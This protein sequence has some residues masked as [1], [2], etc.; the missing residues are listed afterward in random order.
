[1]AGCVAARERRYAEALVWFVLAYL[2]PVNTTIIA[3]P[4]WRRAAAIVALAAAGAASF[5][6]ARGQRAAL[7]ATALA[8]F[9]VIPMFGRVVNYPKL[10][11]Q[12][13]TQ[14]A[15]WAR[16]STPADAVFM[17]PAFGKD[18]SP[19]IFRSEAL[20]A[21]YVDWKGGGQV[22]YLK[23]LGEQWWA[24][25]QQAGRLLTPDEYR[26]LGIDYVVVRPGHGP[27][28]MTPVFE[29]ARFAVYRL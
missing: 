8:A 1:V 7:A 9:F 2:V 6:P 26:G 15:R 20:R 25:W 28:G 22:N 13:V 11:T 18:L 10:H 19:G 27:P 4:D 24:R 3:L 16:A 23:E 5:R 12:E 29:N 17:F 14:L 21:V